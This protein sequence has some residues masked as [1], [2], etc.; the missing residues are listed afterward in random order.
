MPDLAK[1]KIEE[2]QIEYNLNSCFDEY[3][4][5]FK[6]NNN[7]FRGIYDHSVSVVEDYFSSGLMG[8][9]TKEK[10]IPETR[11]SDYYSENFPL[12]LAHETITPVLYPSEWTFDML[13]KASL[14]TLRLMEILLEYGYVLKDAHYWN[15]LYKDNEPVWC[16]ITSFKKANKIPYHTFLEFV[17]HQFQIVELFALSPDLGR[18]RLARRMDFGM[19]YNFI[20]KYGILRKGY[21]FQRA[22]KC[23]RILEKIAVSGNKRY[24]KKIIEWF[25]AR[26]SALELSSGSTQWRDYQSGF[27]DKHK[28]IVI[29]SENARLFKIAD[30]LRKYKISASL[31]LGGNQGV[32][33]QIL[34]ESGQVISAFCSD[35]DESAVNTLYK[36]VRDNEDARGSLYPI[37]YDFMNE[38]YDEYNVNH[39]VNRL[40]NDVVVAL[41]MT[42]HLI[43]SQHINMDIMFERLAGLTTRYIV[44]EFMPLGLWGG[45]DDMP[46]VPDWYN[47]DTFKKCMAKQFNILESHVLEK[48]RIVFIGEK[49]SK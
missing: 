3:G 35:F 20:Y 46:L 8:R 37:Y 27:R 47:V 23:R 32:F 9:L 33:S 11:I 1:E 43:L 17:T 19:S 14:M 10:I 39:L 45:G 15:I 7:F 31:E 13:K 36:I 29:N 21:C 6:Y 5:V 44:V 30:L 26:L 42:H 38:A 49:N 25:A 40:K 48:N 41:A 34:L 24:Y 18:E 28:Q 22:E 4:R 2:N 16:D 12:I